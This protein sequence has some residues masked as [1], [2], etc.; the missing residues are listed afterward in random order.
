MLKNLIKLHLL[1]L[2]I[3]SVFRVVL[4]LSNTEKFEFFTTNMFKALLMGIRFDT[5]I[6]CYILALPS[7][8]WAI[9]YNIGKNNKLLNRILYGYC[10][11]MFSLAFV[12]SAVDIPYFNQFFSRLDRSAFLWM[13]SPSFIIEM[14]AKDFRLWGYFIPF[15]VIL[16]LFFYG[17]NRIFRKINT[18]DFSK[19]KL[20]VSL[21]M[22]I[23][24]LGLTFLGIR[25]RI[26][27]KSPIRVGTAYFSENA[28]LNK[29]GL[30]PNFTLIES[31]LQKKTKWEPLMNDTE[32]LSIA[33][34]TL[35]LNPSADLSIIKDVKPSPNNLGKPNVVLIL[36]ESMTAQHLNYFDKKKNLTP[37][38][39]NLIPK[40]IFFEN[41]Y[42]AGI[43]TFNGVFSSIYSYPA[44]WAEHTMKN[45]KYYPN[46]SIKA[47]ADAGYSTTYFTTHDEQ[48]D[49]IGGF[50]MNNNFQKVISQ[51]DYPSSEVKSNL[52][53]PDDFMFRFSI[54]K[55]NEL[56][57]SGKPF[58][59]TMMTASNHAPIV[60]PDYYKPRTKDINTQ[61]TEY[62]DW[63][64]G[65]FL[66]EAEKQE[67]FKNTIFVL[68]AD[69]GAG[70]DTTY[71][72]S[73]SYNHIPLFF[74]APHLLKPEIKTDLAL[75]IDALPTILGLTNIT[76]T[77]Q[78]MGINLWQEKRD[79]AY[80]GADDKIG[81]INQD[82]Y[83]IYRKDGNEGLYQYRKKD[84]TN[85]AKQHPKLVKQMKDYAFG[86]IQ[87]AYG[88]SSKFK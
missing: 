40:S 47:F 50:L 25:G 28:F 77:K 53:V 61:A 54:P 57:Q 9:A 20:N 69:H 7:L 59:I 79:F 63:S 41:T 88:A 55:I 35:G 74:Y 45:I 39:D 24:V 73:L 82:F 19:R 44:L 38:L 80:F 67:W 71:E 86:N 72:M 5:V 16:G 76:Y 58:F 52:G 42:S 85:Y 4:L 2:V 27:R 81:V 66:K 36:M 26:E 60:I 56:H 34:Q 87:T 84:Q 62:A 70:F 48:F 17:L 46:N 3:F 75:Q 14:V 33:K 22:S 13:D 23:L 68:M 78:N 49:N 1:S 83:Y 11:V 8:L 29:L 43:H 15:F 18:L 12:I 65:Q 37:V 31:L 51:K 10:A 6:T 64:I 21:V 32:A 30:N